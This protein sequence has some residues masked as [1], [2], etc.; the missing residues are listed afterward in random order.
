MFSS[1]SH[2]SDRAIKDDRPRNGEVRAQGHD[3]LPDMPCLSGDRS[4]RAG[5]EGRA[6]ILAGEPAMQVQ[7]HQGLSGVEQVLRPAWCRPPAVG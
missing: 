2:A 6:A 3:K 1:C 4:G 5:N 7:A